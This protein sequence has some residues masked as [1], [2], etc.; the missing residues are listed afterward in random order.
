MKRIELLQVLEPRLRLR[1][2]V[3]L[4]H[5]RVA[6][7]I[8][9]Q[10]GE[11]GV[12]HAA[13]SGRASARSAA[14]RSASD[15]RALPGQLLRL[16]DLARGLVE[17]RSARARASSL[18]RL[19]RGVAEPALGH[20]D[21][22][23]ELQVVGRV[24]RDLEVG[25][26]VLDLLALVEA[27]AADHAVGQPQRDEAVFEGA[28]LERGP[29]QDRHLVEARARPSAAPRCPRRWCAPPPRRPRRRS[30]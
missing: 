4:P 20:I 6:G 23:L 2:L 1:A 28:H 10:L 13:R 8:Q 15:L 30:P 14:M 5:L 9:D 17:R 18:T 26:G 24:E 21:D 27:R 11:L 25:D 29:H 16:D 19:H 12:L 22:A 3:R 7:L